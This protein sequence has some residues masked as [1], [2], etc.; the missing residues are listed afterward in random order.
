AQFVATV[1]VHARVV[2]TI[3]TANLRGLLTGRTVAEARQLLDASSRYGDWRYTLST[4]PN[5][6]GRMP[7]TADLI[8]ITVRQSGEDSYPPVSGE[9]APVWYHALRALLRPGCRFR[10][11]RRGAQ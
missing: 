3:D 6:A 7:Q 5:W 10:M 1:R 8:Q 9:C 2:P 4:S 11:D